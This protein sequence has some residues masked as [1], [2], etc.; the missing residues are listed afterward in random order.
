MWSIQQKGYAQKVLNNLTHVFTKLQLSTTYCFL[1]IS[2]P[3]LQNLPKSA[4]S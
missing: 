3:S 2:F 4:A 1:D